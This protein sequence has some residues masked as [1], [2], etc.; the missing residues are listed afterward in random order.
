LPLPECS[1]NN[2]PTQLSEIARW[3]K[4][5]EITEFLLELRKIWFNRKEDAAMFKLVWFKS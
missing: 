3:L 4:E 1:I 2:K 5:A